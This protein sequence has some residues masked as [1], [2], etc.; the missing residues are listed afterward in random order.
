M[1]LPTPTHVVS[2]FLLHIYCTS[3]IVFILRKRACAR[4]K[5]QVPP[6]KNSHTISPHLHSLPTHSY[7]DITPP[8]QRERASDRQSSITEKRSLR[9]G[10]AN[11]KEKES[12][13]A[14]QRQR[15]REIETL[16]RVCVCVCV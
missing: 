14:E 12:A 13:R 5:A 1:L 15:Q 10:V 8:E 11:Q 6:D 9:R 16:G 7:S 3:R 4:E 2:P